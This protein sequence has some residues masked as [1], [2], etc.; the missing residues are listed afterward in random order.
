MSKIL[1]LHQYFKT[2]SEAGAS[3]SFFLAKAMVEAGHEV[4]MITQGDVAKKILLDGIEVHYLPNDY[5]NQMGVVERIRSFWRFY[6]LAKKETQKHN[7]DLVYATSTPLSMGWLGRKLARKNKASYVFEVRDL[8]PDFP[9]QAGVLPFPLSGLFRLMERLIYRDARKIVACSPGI[10]SEVIRRTIP[11][12]V[13]MASNFS[14]F[15]PIDP[16]SNAGNFIY[17]GSLGRFN[18]ME[19]WRPFLEQWQQVNPGAQWFVLGEG[20]HENFVKQLAT[21]F[22]F[23]QLIPSIPRNQ[24]PQ[25][26]QENNIRYSWVTFLNLPV[27]ETNSPNKLFDSWQWGLIPIINQKGWMKEMC[28]DF[29]GIYYDSNQPENCIK[30]ILEINQIEDEF[31]KYV[32][33]IEGAR[34]RFDAINILQEVVQNLPKDSKKRTNWA[35]VTTVHSSYDQRLSQRIPEIISGRSEVYY[36]GKG[37]G[38]PNLS[39][40]LLRVICFYPW[41]VFW[42][43]KHKIKGVHLSDPELLPLGIFLKKLGFS[44]VWDVHEDFDEQFFLKSKRSI[45]ALGWMKRL[46]NRLLKMNSKLLITE[47]YY[48][49]LKRYQ[50]F[51]SNLLNNYPSKYPFEIISHHFDKESSHPKFIYVGVI[52]EHRGIPELLEAW[53]LVT[54]KFPN[55]EL[56]LVGRASLEIPSHIKHLEGSWVELAAQL[57]GAWAGISF[58]KT[59]NEATQYPLKSFPTKIGEYLSLGLPVIANSTNNHKEF[60]EDTGVFIPEIN[61]RAIGNALISF[62]EKPQERNLLRENSRIKR[63]ELQN[64]SATFS[65]ISELYQI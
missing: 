50:G 60:L 5:S 63:T 33:G 22:S 44:I 31:Q 20:A 17:F 27:L 9:I 7:F 55:A 46:E 6:F 36:L 16:N 49:D 19:C 30:T 11:G 52:N 15:P 8:W 39:N 26:I 53:P 35:V 42:L 29:A 57:S 10:Y 62:V 2:P 37:K 38:L 40:P 18:G 13:I 34:N 1:Y 47:S 21:E 61:S 14:P 41:I 12:K 28:D 45:W 24:L 58:L 25:F 4:V 56:I 65:K 51:Q 48:K 54:D 3:R 64:Y 32:S 23:I 43:F 59:V